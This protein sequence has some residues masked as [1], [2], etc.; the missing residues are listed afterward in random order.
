M[1]NK[2]QI[3][4]SSVASKKPQPADIEVG[5]LAVNL[6]DK[7]LYTK[8]GGNAII[9]LSNGNIGPADTVTANELAVTGNGT[10]TQYLRSDG[11]G[12]FSWATPTDTTYAGGTNITLTG[13]TFNLDAALTGLTDVTTAAVSIGNWEIKLDGNDL[14]FVYNGTDVMRIT[15]AG[16][17]IAAKDVTA[18]GA[19]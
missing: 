19:P 5:E 15:T 16:A 18:F 6:A 2:V 7:K 4:R 9:E 1:T 8:D 14:R 10:A 11:D 12:T 3:K 13:T 17:V